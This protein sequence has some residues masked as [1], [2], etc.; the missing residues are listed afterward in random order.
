MSKGSTGEKLPGERATYEVR[1]VTGTL[2]F[3]GRKRPAEDRKD[4]V[5]FCV[6]VL[7]EYSLAARLVRCLLH[8]PMNIL[9]ARSQS[10]FR[11]ASVV[12]EARRPP[13]GV[14][15]DTDSSEHRRRNHVRRRILEHL[16]ID[17]AE[18]D[19][20]GD[21]VKE[22]LVVLVPRCFGESPHERPHSRQ[23]EAEVKFGQHELLHFKN[24]FTSVSIIANVH[25]VSDLPGD[26]AKLVKQT[27]QQAV[28]ASSHV[29]A[30]L[31]PFCKRKA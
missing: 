9:R 17:H 29:H 11:E 20:V 21:N 4:L 26:T 31:V 18:V 3:Q 24:L 8:Q 27:S 1:P 28:D 22:C 7:F 6:R 19:D 23:G 15:L 25:V 2:S 16:E 14:P 30:C 10:C 5:E 13:S 12:L